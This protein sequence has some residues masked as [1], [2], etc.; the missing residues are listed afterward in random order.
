MSFGRERDRKFGLAFVM[1]RN[2][3]FRIHFSEN[4]AKKSENAY[5]KGPIFDTKCP[6]ISGFSVIFTVLSQLTRCQFCCFPPFLPS[7]A[8]GKR[9][10]VHI[11]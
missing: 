5:K 9:E 10:N 4:S 8:R 7:S 6:K 2:N 11:A 1:L 3:D